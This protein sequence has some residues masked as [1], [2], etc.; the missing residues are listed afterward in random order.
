MFETDKLRSHQEEANAGRDRICRDPKNLNPQKQ[1][2]PGPYS[3]SDVTETAMHAEVQMIY[4]YASPATK[5]WYDRGLVQEGPTWDDWIIRWCLWHAFRYRDSRNQPFAENG[6]RS[7]NSP[8]ETDNPPDPAPPNQTT[9]LVYSVNGKCPYPKNCWR[10]FVSMRYL[11]YLVTM[12]LTGNIGTYY[13]PVRD[14]R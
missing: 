7:R 14:C 3:A 4:R 9:T 2:T 10:R 1:G 12:E 6:R 8:Y 11:S 5:Q 13:D